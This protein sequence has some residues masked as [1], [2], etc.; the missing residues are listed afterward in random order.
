VAQA[1]A[2]RTPNPDALKFELDVGLG[3]ELDARPGHDTDDELAA[4]LLGIEG[5]ASVFGIND[6]VTVT[7]IPGADWDLIV[8]GV[9]EAVADHLGDAAEPE[10]D[11]RLRAAQELLR[12]AAS[13]PERTPVDLRP[14][15][16]DESRTD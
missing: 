12:E 1:R 3:R 15:D 11:E 9:E 16:P 8:C 7:R 4:A 10:G 5:V 14:S 2:R 13:R 6:F